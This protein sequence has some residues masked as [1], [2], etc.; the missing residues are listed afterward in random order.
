MKTIPVFCSGNKFV[1]LIPAISILLFSNLTFAADFSDDFES[2]NV[3]TVANFDLTGN[4]VTSNGITATASGGTAFTIG[5]SALYQSGN[6]S[7]MVEPAGTNTRGTH[8]GSGTITFNVPMSRISFGVRKDPG[9]TL[10]TVTLLDVDCNVAENSPI[11]TAISTA[12]INIDFTITNGAA[13]LGSILFDV[14]GSNPDMAAID[15][16]GGTSIEDTGG[17]NTDPTACGNTDPTGDGNTESSGGGGNISIYLLLTLG[18][19]WA[20]RRRYPLQY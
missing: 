2:T 18:I 15:D 4:P 13:P 16:L 8:N 12:W 14:F 7:W 9:I 19:V 6:K 20:I 5:N 3:T 10:A 1:H 17:G 11:T